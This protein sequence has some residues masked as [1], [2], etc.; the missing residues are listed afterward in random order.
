MKNIVHKTLSVCFGIC[1][2]YV[3]SQSRYD[4]LTLQVPLCFYPDNIGFM[5]QAPETVTITLAGLRSDLK[6]LT[7][8]QMAAHVNLLSLNQHTQWLAISAQH[9]FLPGNIKMVQSIPSPVPVHINI[10][11]KNSLPQGV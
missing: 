7:L 1:I 6:Q 8:D 2:W 11:N 4:N 10:E 9:L 5:V 3:I